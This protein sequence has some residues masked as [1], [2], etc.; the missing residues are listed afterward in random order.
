MQCNVLKQNRTRGKTAVVLRTGSPYIMDLPD[1]KPKSPLFPA[2]RRVV[3]C[4]TTSVEPVRDIT[5]KVDFLTSGGD[6]VQPGH[7]PIL[8]NHAHENR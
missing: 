4:I 8:T 3:V 2:V 5:N 6:S 1:G 7:P